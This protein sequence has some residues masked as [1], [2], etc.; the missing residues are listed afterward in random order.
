MPSGATVTLKARESSDTSW[1]FTLA[2]E[3]DIVPFGGQWAACAAATIDVKSPGGGSVTGYPLTWTPPNLN[4]P[5][6]SAV[7][8][9]DGTDQRYRQFTVPVDGATGDYQIQITQTGA[10]GVQHVALAD[11]SLARCWMMLPAGGATWDNGVY[12]FNVPNTTGFSVLGPPYYYTVVKADGTVVH[13]YGTAAFTPTASQVGL[14]QIQ[15]FGSDVT[16]APKTFDL[17]GSSL[18]RDVSFSAATHPGATAGFSAYDINQDGLVNVVDAQLVV[19][20]ALGLMPCGAGNVNRDGRCDI[21]DV[22]LEIG[23]VITANAG[24]DLPADFGYNSQ[25]PKVA[26]KGQKRN[27]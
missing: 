10:P 8:P 3:C 1:T 12:W 16:P 5:P 25:R 7:W 6:N 2:M 4:Q 24:A 11:C 20:Q 15:Y 26:P 18:T 17:S 23:A 14:W 22:L 19:Y 21:L 13:S 9:L 27:R